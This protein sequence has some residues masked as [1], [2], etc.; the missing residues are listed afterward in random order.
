MD[1]IVA[2]TVIETVLETDDGEAAELVAISW[3]VQVPGPVIVK[4]GFSTVED[5]GLIPVV[6]VTD[7]AYVVVP[8]AGV[9]ASLAFTVTVV[10]ETVAVGLA[11][12][13][14]VLAVMLAVAVMLPDVAVTVVVL[15]FTDDDV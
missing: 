12:S 8:A 9:T 5:V 10:P 2:V 6:G 13:I 4:V 15:G 1:V 3:N 11:V 7:H 14:G